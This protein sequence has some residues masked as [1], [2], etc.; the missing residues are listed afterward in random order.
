[1]PQSHQSCVSIPPS[2]GFGRFSGAKEAARALKAGELAD[3]AA[4]FGAVVGE[5]SA[6]LGLVQHAFS[7]SEERYRLRITAN[8]FRRGV[9]HRMTCLSQVGFSL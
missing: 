7:P 6:C 8:C 2:L 9:Y 5:G 4:G 1:M 3:E